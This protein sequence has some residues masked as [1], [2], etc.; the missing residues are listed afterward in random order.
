MAKITQISSKKGKDDKEVR[1]SIEEIAN[2]FLIIK[3]TEW[4]DKTGYHYET[5]KHYSKENP[6]EITDKSLADLFDE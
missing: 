6:F 3:N 2:G 1:V 5:E 4:H